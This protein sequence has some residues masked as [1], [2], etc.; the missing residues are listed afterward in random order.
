MASPLAVHVRHRLWRPSGTTGQSCSSRR[1]P[2]EVT[3]LLAERSNMLTL[4]KLDHLAFRAGHEGDA[5]FYQ[6]VLPQDG[7][8]WRNARF[9]ARCE[10]AGIRGLGIGDAQAEVQHGAFS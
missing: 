2:K 3:L 4:Q 7:G 1:A 8:A 5:D 9:P 6:G 10:S